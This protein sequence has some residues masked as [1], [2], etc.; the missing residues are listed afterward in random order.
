MSLIRTEKHSEVRNRLKN[1]LKPLMDRRVISSIYKMD[2][3]IINDN[4]LP[5]VCVYIDEGRSFTEVMDQSE[6]D[7]TSADLVIKVKMKLESE[8]DGDDA[9]DKVADE[10]AQ[11]IN[12]DL[13][14]DNFLKDDILS[15][16]FEYLR[17]PNQTYTCIVFRATIDFHE[18]EIEY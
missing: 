5:S 14:L 4:M 6:P 11:I 13:T 8:A 7:I 2:K 10:V 1:L 15:D 17:D 9:L 18:S 16:S 12:A 3:N